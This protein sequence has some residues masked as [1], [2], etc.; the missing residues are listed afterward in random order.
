MAK[1]AYD[2]LEIVIGR[3][4]LF[5]NFKKMSDMIADP[6]LGLLEILASAVLVLFLRQNLVPKMH[7]LKRHL[8]LKIMRWSQ[9]YQL[10]TPKYLAGRVAKRLLLQ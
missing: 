5:Q 8:Q 3:T 9:I 7:Y 4:S 10:H 2:V 1:K 6:S